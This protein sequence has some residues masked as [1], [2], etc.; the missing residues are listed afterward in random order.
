MTS[1]VLFG[2]SGFIGKAAA[3]A[4]SQVGM[5]VSGVAT[6]RLTW[7]GGTEAQAMQ[8]VARYLDKTI[9]SN[10]LS[11]ADV[12]I[13]AAGLTG[14][15]NAREE[16]TGANALLPLLLAEAARR[17]GV[18]RF[19]HVSSA[20]VQGRMIL[21]ETARTSPTN[22]YSESKALGERLLASVDQ[23][24]LRICCYRPTSVQGPNR[25]VTRKVRELAKSPLAVV[26]T[27][28]NDATPQIHVENVGLACAHFA[29]EPVSPPPIILH[30]WEG[31]TTRTFLHSLGGRD[32]R[33]IPR[34]LASV[35]LGTARG[36]AASLKGLNPHT[37]RLEMLMIGQEQRPG[38]LNGES[39]SWTRRFQDWNGL[40][41]PWSAEK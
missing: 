37:R 26:A 2:A 4:L 28:G 19:V 41:D 30:P 25:E 17:A 22:A 32:P 36:L 8:W 13:N 31:W 27:P 1:V 11:G 20:A 14:T 9:L 6:P 24:R 15:R 10:S 38:W 12:V 39:V 35:A 34:Q 21:D 29:S 5:D 3:E 16:L 40:D 18:H 7:D 23:S 33:Q